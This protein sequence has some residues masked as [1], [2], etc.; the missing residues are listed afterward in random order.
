[1]VLYWTLIEKGLIIMKTKI[2]I[3][4]SFSLA[5]CFAVL[6]AA[7]SPN[8]YGISKKSGKLKARHFH[9]M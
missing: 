7:C 1:M 3:I 5:I 8:Y 9:R 6:L 4:K 2:T